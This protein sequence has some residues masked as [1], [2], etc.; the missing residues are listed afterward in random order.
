MIHLNGKYRKGE[1]YCIGL[2][3]SIAMALSGK[4]HIQATKTHKSPLVGEE[5]R[6]KESGPWSV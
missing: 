1:I 4:K 2:V 5:R 6:G 3:A